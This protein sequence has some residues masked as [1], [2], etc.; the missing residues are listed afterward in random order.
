MLTFASSPGDLANASLV[1]LSWSAAAHSDCLWKSFLLRLFPNALCDAKM[2]HLD[3]PRSLSSKDLLKILAQCASCHKLVKHVKSDEGM[4]FFY[5]DRF[6]CDP[7]LL[8]VHCSDHKSGQVIGKTAAKKEY[9]LT[10][11]EIIQS[12]PTVK[13]RQVHDQHAKNERAYIP[14]PA[15]LELAI[16]K[17]GGVELFEAKKAKNKEAGDRRMETR[18]LNIQFRREMLEDA[19]KKRGLDFPD[20]S[21]NCEQFALSG[22]PGDEDEIVDLIEEIDFFVNKTIYLDFIDTF[23]P[24]YMQMIELAWSREP[25]GDDI[26]RSLALYAWAEDYVELHGKEKVRQQPLPLDELPRSLHD[27]IATVFRDVLSPD[28]ILFFDDFSGEEDSDERMEIE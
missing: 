14:R 12:L 21:I 13:Y 9:C 19:L 5:R 26:P 3:Y 6:D 28:Y 1:S 2:R 17:Y 16:R 4:R 25:F 10:E 15:A 27:D 22:I 23:I 20:W 18:S 24:N 7:Y 8:C 11:Q